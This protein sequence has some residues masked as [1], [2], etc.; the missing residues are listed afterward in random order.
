ML[1]SA[2][3]FYAFIAYRRNM[4]SF[5]A[6]FAVLAPRSPSLGFYPLHSDE[7][8]AGVN[9]P[10]AESPETP[11]SALGPALNPQLCMHTAG[12]ECSCWGWSPAPISGPG[13]VLPQKIFGCS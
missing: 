3:S 9:P 13:S 10:E 5:R 11:C 6:T 8:A 4:K 12:A 7:E 2:C 1:K